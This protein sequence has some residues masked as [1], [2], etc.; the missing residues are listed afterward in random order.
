[1]LRA[2]LPGDGRAETGVPRRMQIRFG[3]CLLPVLFTGACS[4]SG[5]LATA[6]PPTPPET[7]AMLPESVISVPYARDTRA[8]RASSASFGERAGAVTLGGVPVA[9]VQ[10][11]SMQVPAASQNAEVD[12]LITTYAASYEVPESLVRRVVKRESNFRPEA[13]NGPYWGLMQILPATARGMGFDGKPADLLD[14]EINLKYAVKYLR[15]AYLVAGGD[16]DQ[17][18]RNYARGYYYDAKRK[19][20][21]EAAGLKKRTRMP[22]TM[23][24]S[25]RA[26]TA[27]PAAGPAANVASQ[28]ETGFAAATGGRSVGLAAAD[29]RSA[30]VLAAARPAGA[31]M[32]ASPADESAGMGLGPAGAVSTPSLG[33][34]AQ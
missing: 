5:Q 9:Y 33:I 28:W 13:R 7:F 6:E 17:A 12:R 20:L 22:E 14:A 2:S 34:A 8:P 19:G 3:L 26:D 24:A 23:V 18:V 1:M 27:M 21:L 25:A 29:D 16:H 30:P 10:S 11:G 4:T 32:G 31:A 15:G